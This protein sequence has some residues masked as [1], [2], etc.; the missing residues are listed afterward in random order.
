M[1]KLIKACLNGPL[2]LILDFNSLCYCDLQEVDFPL[3]WKRVHSVIHTR[4]KTHNITIFLYPKKKK[5][6]RKIKWT[7]VSH[8]VFHQNDN[9]TYT[10][11][12]QRNFNL[13]QTA[14]YKLGI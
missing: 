3:G 9:I 4:V 1:H 8:Q 6:N 12:F 7:L 13:K 11:S 10:S 2:L 5:K 14:C